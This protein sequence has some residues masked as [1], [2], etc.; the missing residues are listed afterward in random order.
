MFSGS[1]SAVRGASGSCTLSA[2]C[3]C[4]TAS[5]LITVAI[6]SGWLITGS[7]ITIDRTAATKTELVLAG[8]LDLK[9]IIPPQAGIIYILFPRGP[10]KDKPHQPYYNHRRWMSQ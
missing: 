6:P 9:G 2:A 3:F 7:A 10:P 8:L 4:V 5:W 1:E